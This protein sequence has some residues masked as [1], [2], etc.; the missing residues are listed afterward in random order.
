MTRA[1]GS[2]THR[3]AILQRHC[4]EIAGFI[5]ADSLSAICVSGHIQQK[6]QPCGFADRPGKDRQ[7]CRKNLLAHGER[8]EDLPDGACPR[9][10]ARTDRV[11]LKT[12]AERAAL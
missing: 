11:A 9:D 1:R 6:A 8:S 2:N 3:R 5:R 10:A 7:S 4:G 12:M